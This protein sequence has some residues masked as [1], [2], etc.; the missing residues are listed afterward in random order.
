MAHFVST[1]GGISKGTLKDNV[2]HAIAVVRE[3]NALSFYIDGALEAVK[4]VAPN[5]SV[6]FSSFVLGHVKGEWAQNW[7]NSFRGYVADLTIWNPGVSDDI[8]PPT[9]SLASSKS[10]LLAAQTA[11]LTFTLSELSNDFVASDI[12][13]SGGTLSNFSGNSTS[14]SATFTPTANSTTNGVVSVASSK[15]STTPSR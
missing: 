10:S 2:W 11:T 14:Y 8:I 15:F 9:I 6:D 13:V 5:Y 3:N 12:T 7:D 1:G 4:S